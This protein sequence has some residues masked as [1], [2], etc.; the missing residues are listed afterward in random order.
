MV[1]RVLSITAI[2]MLFSAMAMA[3]AGPAG[4]SA[5]ESG[6]VAAPADSGGG[7]AGGSGALMAQEGSV[8]AGPGLMRSRTFEMRVTRP[9]EAGRRVMFYRRWLGEWWNDPEIAQ[10]VGLSDQQKQQLEK[11]SQDARLK[12]IDLR[13]NLEKQQV[14]LAP[15]LRA[16]NADEAQV[17]A[18]IDKVTQARAALERARVQ[19]MLASRKVLTEDQ[20][21]KLQDVRA[22]F[23]RRFGPRMS[24]P[25]GPPRMPAAP[26]TPAAPQAPS[27]PPSE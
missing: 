9:M 20:W 7:F 4:R 25:F 14:I 13:A 6:T 12:M 5:E 2:A 21:K 8:G 27:A 15:M 16:Y 26:P 10:R 17:L 22:G 23:Y 1:K 18:Q 19:A 11:I 3:Q 24:R